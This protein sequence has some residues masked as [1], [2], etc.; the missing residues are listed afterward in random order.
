MRAYWR[1]RAGSSRGLPLRP[2][3][4]G[5]LPAQGGLVRGSGC[6]HLAPRAVCVAP[7][8]QEGRLSS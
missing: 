8:D 2:L 1:R 3:E 4:F 6:D 7:V 5:E